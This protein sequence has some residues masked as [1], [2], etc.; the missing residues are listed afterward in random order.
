MQVMSKVIRLDL[1]YASEASHFYQKRTC[2]IAPYKTE[3][4]EHFARRILAYL[5]FFESS[6]ELAKTESAGKS[7]DL[8]VSDNADHIKLWCNVDLLSE[9]HMQRASHQADQVI[10]FL[11]EAQQ[12]KIKSQYKQYF[13]NVRFHSLSHQHQQEFCAMLKGHMHLDLW[14]EDDK[15][16][17]TDGEHTFELEL[18]SAAQWQ[19]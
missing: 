2:Y 3:L 5:S 6:P 18:F 14:R 8:F 7:P 10:L 4:A 15:L 19:H 17:I 16:L 9:K 12:K 13:K 11:D 1:N